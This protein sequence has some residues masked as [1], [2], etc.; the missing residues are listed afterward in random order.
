M[1]VTQKHR[2][3]LAAMVQLGF[4]YNKGAVQL[5]LISDLG[6][7]PHAYLEQL[8]LDLKKHGLVISTRGSKGGYQLSRSAN[9]IILRDIFTAIDPLNCESKKG[10]ALAF[11]W[12]SLNDHVN[13]YLNVSLDLILKDVI[14]R[15]KVLTYII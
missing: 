15:E 8:I 13:H 6:N 2:Y 10:D 1:N 12:D 3:A 7:I 4:N 11:F 5:R 14:Q 9:E